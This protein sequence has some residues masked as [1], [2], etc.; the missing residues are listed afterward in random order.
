MDRAQRGLRLGSV[1]EV[2]T[3]EAC[4]AWVNEKRASRTAEQAWAEDVNT[5]WVQLEISHRYGSLKVTVT[6]SCK[7]TWLS[8]VY[9]YRYQRVQDGRWQLVT[10]PKV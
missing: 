4:K 10:K 1:V 5:T 2:A 8:E 3:R 6:V 9:F 7:R